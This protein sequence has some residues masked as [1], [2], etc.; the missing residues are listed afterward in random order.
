M[1][2]SDTLTISVIICAYTEERWDDLCQSINAVQQ[3]TI[4]P[5]QILLVIDHNPNLYTRATSHIRGV[6]VMEN[7]GAQGLGGARNRGVEAATS[8]IVAFLDDDAVPDPVWLEYLT[9]PFADEQVLGV[10]GQA[11]PQYS[12]GRREWFPEEF[13]WVVGCTYR[14]MPETAARVRNLHG[15]NM[16][17]RREVFESL[18]G[19][20][21]GY[22]CDETELCIRLG[23]QWPTAILMHEPRAKVLHHVPA[24]R[25]TWRY[26]RTRCYFEGNSK[27]V[28]AWLVGSQYG[29]ATERAYTRRVLPAG[30]ARGFVD[31]LTQREV[32]PLMRA[33]AIV[34]GLAFTA[35]G[36][37]MGKTRPAR[38][39]RK[40]GFTDVT[41]LRS[42][43]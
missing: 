39:A 4:R 11:E 15:C 30:V 25:T 22:G 35:A 6:T 40:R 1:N 7:Q 9:A 8:D 16:S 12:A 23:Q 42:A 34:A 13:N 37:L 38:E 19:F 29:L 3:Q 28:I 36:F 17:L 43:G 24:A 10:G 27:A 14:G 20:R 21:L 5:Q 2:A 33:G 18:G 31:A 32:A 26:F 41:L